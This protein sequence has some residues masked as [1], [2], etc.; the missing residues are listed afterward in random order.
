MGVR[1]GSGVDVDVGDGEGWA[2]GVAVL[3]GSKVGVDVG[4]GVLGIVKSSIVIAA[5]SLI[6]AL[7]ALMVAE[8]E[9][10]GAVYRPVALIEPMPDVLVQV[11]TG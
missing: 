5:L 8:P 9:A 11:K 10:A 1:V 7:K 6:E 2:V 3:D 4:V